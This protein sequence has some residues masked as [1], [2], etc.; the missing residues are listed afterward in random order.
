MSAYNVL[1]SVQTETCS[2]TEVSICLFGKKDTFNL[3][4]KNEGPRKSHTPCEAA[5]R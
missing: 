5:F 1:Q 3:L 4:I 2:Q